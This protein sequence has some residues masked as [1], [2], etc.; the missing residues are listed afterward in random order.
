[1]NG[2]TESLLRTKIMH[3]VFYERMHNIRVGY[4][5]DCRDYVYRLPARKKVSRPIFGL[6]LF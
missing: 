6:R 1:M 2:S 3:S 5:K 4:S